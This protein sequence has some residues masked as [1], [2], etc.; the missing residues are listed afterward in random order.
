MINF[1]ITENL[2]CALSIILGTLLLIT[3]LPVLYAIVA[4][5][6]LR[7]RYG[8]LA[9][10]ILVSAIGGL[11]CFIRAGSIILEVINTKNYSCNHF[12]NV[13]STNNTPWN[14]L[15]PVASYIE[16]FCFPLLSIALLLNSFDRLLALCNPIGYYLHPKFY[17]IV[18]LS[19]ACLFH[20]TIIIY[21]TFLWPTICYVMMARETYFLLLFTRMF[22]STLS[23]VVM[24]IVL[25]KLRL[26]IKKI[27]WNDNRLN[28]FTL[29]QRGYTKAMLFSCLFTFTFFIIPNVIAYCAKA[30]NFFNAD[31]YNSYLKLIS[32]TC[33]LDILVIMLYRQNDIMSETLSRYPFLSRFLVLFQFKQKV[34]VKIIIPSQCRNHIEN[35]S[36]NT[37]PILSYHCKLGQSVHSNLFSVHQIHHQRVVPWL[38]SKHLWFS[39][40]YSYRKINY[41]IKQASKASE[42]VDLHLRSSPKT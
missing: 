14:C 12:D 22:T 31:L 4:N 1:D 18:Q 37:I 15:G 40:K 10:L 24:L 20:G 34:T 39:E 29:R 28:N 32:Y 8:I 9:S 36:V 6:K 42:R 23:I 19:V 25:V 38:L 33:T 21:V 11:N 5:Y 2:I 41:M 16:L 17:L 26:Q 13:S 35:I 7:I 3:N 27:A 30:F